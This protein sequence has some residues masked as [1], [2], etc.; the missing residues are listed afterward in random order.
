MQEEAA[1]TM[2]CGSG[3]NIEGSNEID[4]LAAGFGIGIDVASRG[5]QVGVS[6]QHLNVT[7]APADE[8]DF[9]RGVGD[10]CSP[11]GVARTANEAEAA[12]EMEE[13][14]GDSRRVHAL[15]TFAVND[16]VGR[17][18][19]ALSIKGDQRGTEI[20]RDRYRSSRFHLGDA[21]F[22]V[23]G[24]PDLTVAA[25]H[26]H[27]IG[28]SDLFCTQPS[29]DGQKEHHDVPFAVP[30]LIQ[31]AQSRPDLRCAQGLSLLPRQPIFSQ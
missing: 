31:I 28:A 23:Q 9:A 25:E 13:P 30:R 22:K 8:A 12:V 15:A 3:K 19:I 2:R 1:A 24:I 29:P 11:A 18:G 7:E 14:L 27:P 16:P 4:D 5:R 21:I 26:H 10:E 20:V 6:R 17:R